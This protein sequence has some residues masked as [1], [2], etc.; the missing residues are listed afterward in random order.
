MASLAQSTSYYIDLFPRVRDE[1]LPIYINLYFSEVALLN[2]TER[3]SF[4]VYVNNKTYSDPIIPPY[5]STYEAYI[6]NVTAASINYLALVPTPDSTLPPLINAFEV[7][8]VTE[9]A[10]GTYNKDG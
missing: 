7:Y 6:T 3:R 9:L 10:D 8:T 4:Q 2:A 1:V 5:Q